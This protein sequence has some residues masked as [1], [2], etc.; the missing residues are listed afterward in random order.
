[1]WSANLTNVKNDVQSFNRFWDLKFE[2]SPDL[3]KQLGWILKVY[4]EPAVRETTVFQ[5]K[6]DD[7][8]TRKSLKSNICTGKYCQSDT[9]W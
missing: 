6:V 7:C 4:A 3:F 5:I 9:L 2:I 8:K 1:M